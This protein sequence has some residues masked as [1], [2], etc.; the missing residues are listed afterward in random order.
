[1]QNQKFSKPLF[2]IG[3]ARSGTTM[4]GELMSHHPEIAYWLEPKYIWRYGNASAK[5]DLRDEAQATSR[6]IKFIRG[7]FYDFISRK[8]KTRF[9]EKTPSN[10]FRIPFIYKV[11]PNAHFIYITRDG[12]DVILSAEKK[13][14]SQPDRSALLRR[15]MSWEIPL[16][17]WPVYLLNFLRDVPGRLL[18]PKRGFIWG[19]YFEG[20]QEYRKS[21]S[22]LETCAKQW[23]ESVITAEKDLE[24]V[25]SSQ[26]LKIKYE[27]FVNQPEN[28]LKKRIFE[29]ASLDY[30]EDEWSQRLKEVRSRGEYSKSENEKINKIYPMI[31]G[32]LRDLGY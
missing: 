27:D 15:M 22:V 28:V 11:F 24:S 8:Q 6:V 2:I 1:M 29:F 21:H 10:V 31:E 7:K 9:L 23:L 12:R 17:E 25:P 26:C 13:W 32:K 19:P 30:N 16:M 5:S 18:F 3:A 14:T 4:L 20:I